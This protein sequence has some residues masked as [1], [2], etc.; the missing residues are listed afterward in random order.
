VAEVGDRRD[1]RAGVEGDVEGLVELLVFEQEG[2]V[3]QPGDDDQV[4]GGGDRQELGQPLDD[5]E[6]HGL[7]DLGHGGRL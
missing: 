7:Q 5:P 2:V 6:E 3:L 1:Q 4:A